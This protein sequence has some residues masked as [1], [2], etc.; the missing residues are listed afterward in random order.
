MLTKGG[1]VLTDGYLPACPLHQRGQPGHPMDCEASG[2]GGSGKLGLKVMVQEGTGVKPK[3]MES[4]LK[5]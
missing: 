5:T 2:E 1:L 4:L 3:C